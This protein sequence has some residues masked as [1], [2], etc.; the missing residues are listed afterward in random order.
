MNAYDDVNCELPAD[1]APIAAAL[2]ALAQRDA[3]GAVGLEERLAR[4]T[5]HA[6]PRPALRLNGEFAGGGLGGDWGG[7]EP[8]TVQT[9]QRFLTPRRLAAAVALCAGGVAIW[10]AMLTGGSAQ[11][12]QVAQSANDEDAE[13]R[14][15]LAALDHSWFG[16]SDLDLL[17]LEADAVEDSLSWDWSFSSEG[18][19]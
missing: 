12:V 15:V 13:Y 11:P 7:G 2:D 16:E 17:R 8:A 4:A 14:L 9:V 10:L 5:S 19:L 6:L 3:A 1:I 18:A